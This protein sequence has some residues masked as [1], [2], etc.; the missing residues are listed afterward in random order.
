MQTIGRQTLSAVIA[1]VVLTLPIPAMAQPDETTTR[2]PLPTIE[3]PI[4]TSFL[5]S[6]VAV[7][8]TLDEAIILAVAGNEALRAQGQLIDSAR[9]GVD[10]AKSSY[11]FSLDAT[12]LGRQTNSF[13]DPEPV[14]GEPDLSGFSQE[15]WINS[16]EFR[17]LQPIP[18]FGTQRLLVHGAELELSRQ[19]AIFL[20]QS[21]SLRQQVV[22]SFFRAQ[23]AQRALEVREDEVG[24]NETNLGLAESRFEAGVSP[25]FDVTRAEVQLLN[26]RDSLI[27][28]RRDAA[29]A[30]L[31]FQNL[32]GGEAKY[33]PSTEETAEATARVLPLEWEPLEVEIAVMVA[34]RHRPD[35]V[36]LRLAEEQRSNQTSLT[37][38]RPNLGLAG[39]LNYSDAD[40]TFTGSNSTTVAL[41]MTVPLWDGGRDK[42]EVEQGKAEQAAIR[43]NIEALEQGVGIEVQNAVMA[44]QEASARLE[45][46][47]RT[48]DQA[49]EALGMAEAG[50]QE[51]VLIYLDLLEAQNG[52]T[53]AELNRLNAAT[54]LAVAEAELVR[55]L[56]FQDP[57][58]AAAALQSWLATPVEA[59]PA[60]PE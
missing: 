24:R 48:E 26:A 58:Q 32:L 41:Q 38:R 2:P 45:T 57:S 30:L 29:L 5:E 36:Q 35:L 53:A 14:P 46:A 4:A 44:L 19:E 31:N 43:T 11:W 39:T 8:V 60:P 20:Q 40:S 3:T 1:L 56:G 42:A 51:G 10:V 12:V 27:R 54:D 23:L 55:A 25:R 22:S 34:Q 21:Q 6:A 33:V 15:D 13:P 59:P 9:A 7:P 28:A 18:V 17:L 49:R 50:F 37:K 47:R 16:L 52:L